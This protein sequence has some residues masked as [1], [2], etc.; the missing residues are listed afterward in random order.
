MSDLFSI[1]VHESESRRRQ[2]KTKIGCCRFSVRARYADKIEFVRR[3]TVNNRSRFGKCLA[4]IADFEPDTAKILGWSIFRDYPGR[5]A[6]HNVVNKP[7]PV[8]RRA[9]D[10]DKKC[11]VAGL[12]RIVSDVGCESRAVAKKLGV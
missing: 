2:G 6:T 10:S 1:A 11:A 9:F 8:D 12:A 3:V 7:V 4:G 5:P